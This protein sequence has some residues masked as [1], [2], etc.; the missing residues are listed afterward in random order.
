MEELDIDFISVAISAGRKENYSHW[1]NY[2]NESRTY[3]AQ[4]A[5][6]NNPDVLYDLMQSLSDD[7]VVGI[8]RSF[9]VAEKFSSKWAQKEKNPAFVLYRQLIRRSPQLRN[10]LDGWIKLHTNS[11]CYLH[12][13]L[14]KKKSEHVSRRKLSNV[15]LII[16]STILIVVACILVMPLLSQ[17][18]SLTGNLSLFLIYTVYG[19][20]AVV[21]FM[22]IHSFFAGFSIAK[23]K[24]SQAEDIFEMIEAR[25]DRARNLGLPDLFGELFHKHLKFYPKWLA[26]GHKDKICPLISEITKTSDNDLNFILNGH[27]YKID[28]IERQ[29]FS[30][31]EETAMLR[32]DF[33]LNFDE[34]KVLGLKMVKEG[35]GY[36]SEWQV[37]DITAFKEAD[38]LQDFLDLRERIFS[39]NDENSQKSHE[40]K[41]NKMKTDF[42]L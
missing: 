34:D 38:W 23:A 22:L 27:K 40:E 39:T 12:Y 13:K 33:E 1:R 26:Q 14:N 32:A 25:K 7:E 31:M 30:A 19:L 21:L 3:K 2:L 8:I 4:A 10:D 41:V 24:K 28:F 6:E 16:I 37:V 29:M 35:R 20:V 17:K 15:Q 5:I 11:R 36:D 9:I 42:G 18:V